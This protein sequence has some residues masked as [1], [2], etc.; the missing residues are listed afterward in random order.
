MYLPLSVPHI[1]WLPHEDFKGKSGASP[2]GDQVL[3]A[4]YIL[5]E[6]IFRLDELKISEKTLVI[7][8]SDNGPREGVNGHRSAGDLRGYKGSIWKGGH[9]VPF[10]A[11][12]PGKIEPG[13]TSDQIVTLTDLWQPVLQLSMEFYQK[14]LERIVTIFCPPCWERRKE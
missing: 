5:G 6:I 4:D 2:R 10:I 13:T 11:K 7:F 1:P 12:W 8:T 14:V 3:M 9:R